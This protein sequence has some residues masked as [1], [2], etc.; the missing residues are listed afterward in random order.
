MEVVVAGGNLE[1]SLR[2]FK[3]LVQKDGVHTQIKKRLAF[4]KPSERERE[5]RRL[6]LQRRMRLEKRRALKGGGVRTHHSKA[7]YPN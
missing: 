7:G 4:I 5:K 2:L 1:N 6:S 3:K